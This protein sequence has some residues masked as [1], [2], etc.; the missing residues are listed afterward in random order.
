MVQRIGA[1]GL[2]KLQMSGFDI[3]T[4]GCLLAL[5]EIAPAS[6]AFRKKVLEC[7]SKQRS[8]R[9]FLNA[10]IEYGSG[11]NVV[12]DQL[13]HT[14]AGENILSLII[15]LLSVLDEGA[16]EVLGG[17]F[18]LLKTPFDHTPGI[19]QL[20]EV[21]STCVP[22]SRMMD[23]KDRVARTHEMILTRAF[24]RK[25]RFQY[26]EALPDSDTMARLVILLK[27]IVTETA[28]GTKLV[29]YGI[30]GASWVIEYSKEVLGLDVCFLDEGGDVHPIKGDYNTASVVVTPTA[31]TAQQTEVLR[32]LAS[33]KDI[34][35]SSERK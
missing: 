14:R 29:Y 16:V 10:V 12:I 6:D 20:Q 21:R 19:S 31:A 35:M 24:N 13:L 7:R 34:L 8:R 17:I 33:P 30:T 23:F 22:L 26:R 3:H 9:W 4:I 15:A 18:N 11:T 25:R 28:A 27:D 5:A 32:P 1:E 2:K